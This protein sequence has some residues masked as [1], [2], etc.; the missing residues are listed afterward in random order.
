MNITLYYYF[1]IHSG[2]ER[3]R[4]KSSKSF[5][6]CETKI[7]HLRLKETMNFYDMFSPKIT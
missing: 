3:E 4:N 2:E 1:D 6:V 5:L 7:E